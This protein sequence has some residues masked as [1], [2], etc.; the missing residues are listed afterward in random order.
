MP[1]LITGRGVIDDDALL[2]RDPLTYGGPNP[3][4]ENGVQRPLLRTL[5][6]TILEL[7]LFGR[8]SYGRRH[9]R[10]FAPHVVSFYAWHCS[11][12]L[13]KEVLILSMEPLLSLESMTGPPT[14]GKTQN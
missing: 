13:S 14:A 7:F 6:Q 8:R 9:H 4:G 2:A 1:I 10:A 3:S 5:S 12:P 11:N